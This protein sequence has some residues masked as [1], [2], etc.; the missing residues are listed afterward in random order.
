MDMFCRSC[1]ELVDENG[2]VYTA[3]LGMFVN[4]IGP[5]ERVQFPLEVNL[6]LQNGGIVCIYRYFDVHALLL[7]L[8]DIVKV[9]SNCFQQQHTTVLHYYSYSCQQP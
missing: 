5:V 7:L 1:I 6:Q 2:V 4:N 9:N 8:L 3:D